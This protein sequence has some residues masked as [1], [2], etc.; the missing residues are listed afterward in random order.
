MLERG[1][2]AGDAI[3]AAAAVMGVVGPHLCGL[4]GDVL[5]M[6]KAPGAPPSALLAAGR[7]GS[8]ADP[9]RLRA[10]GHTAMPQRGDVRSVPVP[11]AVDGWLA[12]HERFGR[13]PWDAVLE[14]AITLA[15]EGFAASLFSRS[16]ATSSRTSPAHPS[17]VRADRSRRSRSSVCRAWR[18]PFGAW[19]RA[20]EKAS[21]VQSSAEPSSSWAM[22]ST[23][24][25]TWRNRWR[26]GRDRSRCRCS[27]MTCGRSLLLPRVISR[28]PAPG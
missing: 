2:T 26:S 20:D 7:A 24:R 6:V 21:M 1:G 10:E 13:V 22:G 8:G 23:R 11:G 27:A 5:A 28:S 18:E 12:L 25:T 3:V 17:S 14:P 16:P 4:G 19:H 15:E 9:R